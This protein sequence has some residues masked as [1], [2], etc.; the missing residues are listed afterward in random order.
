MTPSGS[1]WMKGGGGGEGLGHVTH[2]AGVVRHVLPE[3]RLLRTIR[4]VPSKF[5]HCKSRAAGGAV[6]EGR[7]KGERLAGA[8]L[9]S[10]TTL[11]DRGK[12]QRGVGGPPGGRRRE[13]AG[14]GVA[15]S[16]A[17]GPKAPPPRG[18]AGLLRRTF[19]IPSA[20]GVSSRTTGPHVSPVT[21][22]GLRPLGRWSPTD[23]TGQPTRRRSPAAVVAQPPSQSTPDHGAPQITAHPRSRPTPDHGPPHIAAKPTSPPQLPTQAPTFD[24]GAL[25][26]RTPA[27]P[28]GRSSVPRRPPP[29]PVPPSGVPPRSPA[30]SARPSSVPRRTT[31][32][33]VPPSRV[34]IQLWTAF[35]G[36]ESG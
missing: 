26:A 22:P 18:L 32:R 2:H 7:W 28:A 3:T 16:S 1:V 20:G 6:G 10:R 36:R 29:R 24:S 31:A 33:P 35:R 19:G 9:P 13:L 12:W 4:R 11:P 27:R 17:V 25:H 14:E 23:P 5:L 8:P 34:P 30:R 15:T 21:F